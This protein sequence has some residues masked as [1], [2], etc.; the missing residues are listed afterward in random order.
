MRGHDVEMPA[1]SGNIGAQG[2]EAYRA[3]VLDLADAGL[4]QPGGFGELGLGQ[5]ELFADLGYVAGV[6]R[7]V[8]AGRRID[9]WLYF[10][11]V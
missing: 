3:A 9:V 2:F 7:E 4:R 5:P 10:V 1:E 11:I 6:F 8:R